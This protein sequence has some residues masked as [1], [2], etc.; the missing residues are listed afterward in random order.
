MCFCQNLW[1]PPHTHLCSRF[2]SRTPT[3]IHTH[4]T[5]Q[6]TEELDI[7]HGSLSHQQQQI[8]KKFSNQRF[9]A[10]KAVETIITLN[11]WKTKIGAVKKYSVTDAYHSFQ[12]FF[13][14]NLLRLVCRKLEHR[15]NHFGHRLQRKKSKAA[16]VKR[17]F[18]QQVFIIYHLPDRIW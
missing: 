6:D 5:T 8:I 10:T 4:K 14:Q 16:L 13:V 3:H 11:W 1:F 7:I 17:M 18:H 2:Y 12:V 9:I 15:G